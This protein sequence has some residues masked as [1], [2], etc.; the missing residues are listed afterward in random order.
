MHKY[1]TRKRMGRIH[2]TISASPPLDCSEATRTK[3]EQALPSDRT[4]TDSSASKRHHREKPR[5]RGSIFELGA[6]GNSPRDADDNNALREVERRLFRIYGKSQQGGNMGTERRHVMWRKLTGESQCWF[7]QDLC[8]FFMI[9]CRR[10]IT[11]SAWLRSH[12]HAHQ[13][14]RDAAEHG[15]GDVV[16]VGITCSFV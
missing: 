9:C 11:A 12:T 10:N 1:S 6:K 16:R 2:V 5:G 7:A 15:P 13:C 4:L 3:A 14:R 8:A